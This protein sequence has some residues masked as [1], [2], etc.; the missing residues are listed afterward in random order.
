MTDLFGRQTFDQLTMFPSV[1]AA[2]PAP[3]VTA[4]CGAEI[5]AWLD[6][7][8]GLQRAGLMVVDPAPAKPAARQKRQPVPYKYHTF[9]VRMWKAVA[10]IESNPAEHIRQ[11]DEAFESNDGEF[12][13]AALWTLA[14]T[15]PALAKYLPRF[16]SPMTPEMKGAE[17]VGRPMKEIREEA[18][19]SRLASHDRLVLEY[20]NT[21]WGDCPRT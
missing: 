19:L 17:F 12:M 18:Y 8:G 1:P 5:A 10:F 14:A 6:S 3:P 15:R 2:P 7:D 20:P 9:S 11:L 4:H 16:V 21:N 13:A